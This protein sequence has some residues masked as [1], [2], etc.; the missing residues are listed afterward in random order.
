MHQNRLRGKF[1][2]MIK[3]KEAR[4][5]VF[6]SGPSKICG[7]QPLKKL[8]KYSLFKVVFHKFFFHS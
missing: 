5:R 8:N 1:V 3:G 7:R 4:D 6:K 2:G